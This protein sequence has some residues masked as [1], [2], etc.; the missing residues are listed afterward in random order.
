MANRNIVIQIE[1]YSTLYRPLFYIWEKKGS[2]G[3]E[4]NKATPK[5]FSPPLSKE[6]VY[7]GYDIIS[8]TN[9]RGKIRK[10]NI[11]QIKQQQY[12]KKQGR[13]SVSKVIKRNF[14]K[15]PFFLVERKFLMVKSISSILA[16]LIPCNF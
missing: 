1:N 10:I 12:K 13:L 5:I 9:D 6:P 2:M 15:M 11:S 14:R 16:T 3:R 4:V 8:T 7:P